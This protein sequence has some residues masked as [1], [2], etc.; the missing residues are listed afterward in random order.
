MNEKLRR[1]IPSTMVNIKNKKTSGYVIYFP[2]I[3]RRVWRQ[4]D[5]Q[6]NVYKYNPLCLNG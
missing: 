2:F 6:L 3:Y 1:G 4:N 5:R